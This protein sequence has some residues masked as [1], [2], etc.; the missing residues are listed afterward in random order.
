LNLNIAYLLNSYPMTSTTFIRREIEA[1]ETLGLSI[2][3]F[4]IRV[5]DGHLVDPRDIAEKQRTTYLLTG[6]VG[7]LFVALT[8]EIFL[9][10]RG[11]YRS[12]GVWRQ[13]LRNSNGEFVRHVAYLMQAASFRQLAKFNRV[14]HVHAHFA[15]N[16]TTVAMLSHM[17]GGPSF[18][19]TV[20][21]PDELLDPKQ[22]SFGIKI[23]QAA[24]VVAISTFCK[25][26]LL[27]WASPDHREKI[28]IV[29]CGLALEE[30]DV[31]RDYD[32]DDQTLVCVGRLCPQKGQILIPKAVASLRDEFP[33]LKVILVG[34]GESRR[35]I[36]ASIATYD[37]AD[38]VE[39]RGWIA[40]PDVLVLVRNSRALLLPSY[41]EGLPVVIME[42]L[43]LGRPVISTNIAGIPELVDD[44]CGWL[45]MAGDEDGLM[46]ALRACL[47]CSA[48]E[49]AQKGATGRARVEQL[50]DRRELA[51]SL[52]LRFQGAVKRSSR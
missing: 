30:F 31:S 9:N 38:I 36:E 24:F 48:L 3:R 11:L 25:N 46:A 2:K 23:Q 14:D 26:E 40:N 19:F 33:K 18:S 21:G 10:P 41:A 37:V 29:R 47:K 45:F 15:T 4:G 43:A 22:L 42:A 7:G 16:A 8:K 35:A 28:P 52:Y 27:K 50:H 12:F 39:L 49:L 17:M 20:H 13:L 5:W 34:D 1:L 32:A 44:S 6:N 51:K